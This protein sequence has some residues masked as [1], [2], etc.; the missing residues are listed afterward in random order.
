M[1]PDLTDKSLL[2]S[3][4]SIVLHCVP[5]LICGLIEI[6]EIF[7][8]NLVRSSKSSMDIIAPTRQ[9][10]LDQIRRLWPIRLLEYRSHSSWK[11]TYPRWQQVTRFNILSCRVEWWVHRKPNLT[12]PMD[13]LVLIVLREVKI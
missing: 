6:S 3:P 10:N 2:P 7:R 11:P 1:K 13:P 4:I 9:P 8:P 12:Q 5:L